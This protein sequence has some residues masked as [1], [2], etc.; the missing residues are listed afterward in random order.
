[1]VFFVYRRILLLPLI[2]HIF[3]ASTT[4]KHEDYSLV[5]ERNQKNL[6]QTVLCGVYVLQTITKTASRRRKKRRQGQRNQSRKCQNK[7]L[8]RKASKRNQGE[9]SFLLLIE[10]LYFGVKTNNK[11]KD[12]KKV[13]KWNSPSMP[14]DD[15]NSCVF[16]PWALDK[17]GRHSS[18]VWLCWQLPVTEATGFSINWP[19]QQQMKGSTVHN[20]TVTPSL[21]LKK[22]DSESSSSIC[23]NTQTNS[24][25][26]LVSFLVGELIAGRN[27]HVQNCAIRYDPSLQ[28]NSTLNNLFYW[29]QT[30]TS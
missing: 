2:F 13:K 14:R 6:A 15:W 1:M 5:L 4:T 26:L 20:T 10:W 29:V 30:T 12:E 24:S 8:M 9:T 23:R 22:G 7:K 3:Q 19:D 17:K 11:R 18:R 16:S 28:L 21:L 27:F 25:N